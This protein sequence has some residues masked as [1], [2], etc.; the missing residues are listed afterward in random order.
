MKHKNA[1]MLSK[2]KQN[3]L[4]QIRSYIFYNPPQVQLNECGKDGSI[5]S[6]YIF[7]SLNDARNSPNLASFHKTEIE[8]IIALE[9]DQSYNE[10]VNQAEHTNQAEMLNDIQNNGLQQNNMTPNIPENNHQSFTDENLGKPNQSH[11]DN[12]QTVYDINADIFDIN[13]IENFIP[14]FTE[15]TEIYNPYDDLDDTY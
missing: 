8:R 14:D 1:K 6:T 15:E 2:R 12:P 3:E 9:A 4:H 5:I 10:Q 7:A 13:N 11:H